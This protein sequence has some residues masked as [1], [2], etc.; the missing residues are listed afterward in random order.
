VLVYLATCQIQPEK[1]KHLNLSAFQRQ[2]RQNG[3]IVFYYKNLTIKLSA[4]FTVQIFIKNNVLQTI[5]NLAS[6]FRF[7]ANYVTSVSGV[8]LGRFNFKF[9][10]IQCGC[11]INYHSL[12][13]QYA[14]VKRMHQDKIIKIYLTTDTQTYILCYHK[15]GTFQFR[16]TSIRFIGSSF[17]NIEKLVKSTLPYFTTS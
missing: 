14:V 7:F 4:K 8:R 5:V 16:K 2:V 11:K 1:A 15:N 17:D 10:N 12:E 6:H 13:Q 9:L 3:Y